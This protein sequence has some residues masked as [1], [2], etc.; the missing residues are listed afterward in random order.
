MLTAFEN[1][2]TRAGS[3]ESSDSMV[4]T[5]RVL[6]I[7]SSGGHWT[8]LRR[9]ARAFDGWSQFYACT[10]AGYRTTLDLEERFFSVPEATR[11]NKLRLVHQALTVLWILLRTNPDVVVSTGASPGFFAML[12]GRL[13]RRKTI[14]VDSIANVDEL[15]LSGQ[16]ARRFADLWLTQW[17]HLARPG[18]PKYFGSVV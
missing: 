18:G 5:R 3:D 17:Q 2:T 1:G 6:L 13:L 7:S 10:N 14:W 4:R 11:W 16:Q 12:F 15:S 9:L 8:Q